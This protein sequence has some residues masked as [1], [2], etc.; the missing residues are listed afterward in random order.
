M[1]PASP[2]PTSEPARA[3]LVLAFVV[4]HPDDDV[5][6]AAGLIAK[7]RD[8]PSMRFVLVH[9]T[10]GEAGQ[11]AP[12]SHATPATLGRVRRDEDRAGWASLGRSPDRHE[13][14][15]LPDGELSGL[16]AGWLAERVG[17]LLEDE[18]PDVVCTFGP[19][20]ITAH[21]DHVAVGAATTAAFLRR[22]GSPGPGFRRLFH[23]AIPQSHM[24]KV[25]ARRCEMGLDPLPLAPYFPCPVP[26]ETITHSV[27]QRDVVHH[28]RHMFWL[29]RSQWAPPWSEFDDREWRGAAGWNHFVQAW[30]TP[31]PGHPVADDLFT[32]L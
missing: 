28:I 14:L 5:M 18:R 31:D 17:A 9:A 19:D 27:D 21:P 3:S 10:D 6:G 30:P 24:D 12:G 8:H 7:L 1:D 16:P 11:I 2:G 22:A 13:W 23:V 25:N 29:H 26:D 4:A 15:G 32:D 20:G